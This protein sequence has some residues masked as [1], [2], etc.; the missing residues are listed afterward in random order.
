[1][2]IPQKPLFLF[3]E[4]FFS[5]ESSLFCIDINFFISIFFIFKTTNISITC[6]SHYDILAK[7]RGVIA[8][9]VPFSRPKLPWFTHAY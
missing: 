6:S 1:M 3:I 8:T 4:V 5:K 2:E 7:T 9:A